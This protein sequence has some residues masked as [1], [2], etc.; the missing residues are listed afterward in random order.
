MPSLSTNEASTL[1]EGLA[2]QYSAYS[3]RCQRPCP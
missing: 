1:N 2:A 3:S